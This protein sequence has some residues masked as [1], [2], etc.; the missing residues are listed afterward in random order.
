MLPV[1][2]RTQAD[3][4]VLCCWYVLDVVSTR[5]SSLAPSMREL[6]SH[7]KTPSSYKGKPAARRGRKATGQA[8]SLI[9]GLPKE[10]WQSPPGSMVVSPNGGD[11]HAF[12]I[13]SRCPLHRARPSRRRSPLGGSPDRSGGPRC[14]VDCSYHE[15]RRKLVDGSGLLSRLL[16][17]LELPLSWSLLFSGRLLDAKSFAEPNHHR[18]A[19]RA[20]YG[21]SLL[22]FGHRGSDARRRERLYDLR[23]C[24]GTTRFCREPNRHH[25]FRECEPR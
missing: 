1:E 8:P 9:A 2:A 21:D 16:R 6:F 19:H 12:E 25:E 22:R 10:G 17:N 13:A 11:D 7:G 24:R 20:C 18:Q 5:R 15:Y 3:G 4:F 14:L 23:E